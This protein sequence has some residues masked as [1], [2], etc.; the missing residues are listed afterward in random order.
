MNLVTGALLLPLA[1]SI[2]QSDVFFCLQVMEPITCGTYI[3]GRL[4]YFLLLPTSC[5]L[6]IHKKFFVT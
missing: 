2:Y 4:Q 6:H 3:S 1:K 5:V